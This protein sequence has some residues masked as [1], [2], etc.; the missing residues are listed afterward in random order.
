MPGVTTGL[1]LPYSFIDEVETSVS[2]KNLADAVDAA[3]N[4]SITNATATTKRPAALI[5]RN[6]NQAFASAAAI[7]PITFT[8]EEYDNNGMGNLG[9]NNDRI[10][11]QTAGVY[12]VMGM[13]TMDT[14]TIDNDDVTVAN[15][16]LQLN[17]A[18]TLAA[19]KMRWGTGY[20]FSLTRRFAAADYLRLLFNW[21]GVGTG[22][23]AQARLGAR[24]I[25]SL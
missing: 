3:L 22:N 10:T 12:T 21:T 25:C 6:T 1:A 2:V 23:V 4:T 7:A 20:G 13:W 18:T 24:W 5:T 14:V 19:K 16:V 9:T 11:I 17:G 8:A 15:A